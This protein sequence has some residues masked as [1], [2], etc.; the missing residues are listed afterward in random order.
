M[1]KRKG[2]IL[3]VAALI[4]ILPPLRRALLPFALALLC[5]ALADPALRRLSR[6][7]I[8]RPVCAAM[9]LMAVIL[10]VSLLLGWCVLS[11]AEGVPQW[12]ETLSA[13]LAPGSAARDATYRLMTALPP[14]LRQRVASLLEQA[15]AGESALLPRLISAAAAQVGALLAALPGVLFRWGIFLLACW[16]AMCDYEAVTAALSAA[17]PG[18]WRKALSRWRPS[19][20]AQLRS[21][22]KAQLTLSSL[23]FGELCLGFL[24]L[25]ITPTLP[26]ALAGAA[27][28]LLPFFGSGILL[29]P[30]A[31]LRA[32]QGAWQSGLGLVLLWGTATFTRALLEPRL[33]GRRLGIPPFFSLCAAMIGLRLMGVKGLILFPI[34]TGILFSLL[35]AGARRGHIVPARTPAGAN[36]ARAADPLRRKP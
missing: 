15:A 31:V 5:A 34:C 3:I 12:L 13:A 20:L 8:P 35:P 32:L 17:L 27:I 33:V 6:F 30:L 18:D 24:L 11:L 26:L 2:I 29:W 4:V 28:D 16:Y 21:W 9:V 1:N 10:P 7:R 19:V 23:I 25:R 22:L 14:A 36:A